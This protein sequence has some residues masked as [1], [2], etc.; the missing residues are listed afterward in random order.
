MKDS[1]SAL[2]RQ[3]LPGGDPASCPASTK[4][5]PDGGQYRIE[6]PS[7]EGPRVLAA[8]LDEAAKRRTPLHRVSQG[9]GIMLL[10][11]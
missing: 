11:D 4:R 3:G 7:T 9:S 10:T 8:V 5:F 1:R 2:E 6:I